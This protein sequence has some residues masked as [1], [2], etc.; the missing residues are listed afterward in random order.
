[1]AKANISWLTPDL[2]TG[3]DLSYLPEEARQ[4]TADI[5]RSGVTSIIDMRQEDDDMEFWRD[6]GME[7]MLLPTDDS[8]GHTIPA[9]LFDEA[10]TRSRRV[11]REQGKLLVH[12]HMGVNRGPSV[13]YAVLL[14]R[15]WGV[16]EAWDLIREKRPQAAIYY[17]RDALI[18]D[19]FRRVNERR[20]L[21][22][23]VLDEINALHT[24]IQANFGE[25]EIAHVT[26]HIRARHV[27]DQKTYPF[28]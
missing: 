26:R 14:D 18:A 8:E 17:A 7:Y 3:G 2:A 16:T 22:F 13:A 10:V 27:R 6:R 11:T 25:R 9:R 23:S 21:P 15:G 28:V 12:C 24:H 19:Q 1:M 5:L 4:Q 20:G